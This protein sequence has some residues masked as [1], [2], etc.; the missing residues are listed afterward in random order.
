MG[1]LLCSD[2]GYE[3]LDGEYCCSHCGASANKSRRQKTLSN[4]GWI[5][6]CLVFAGPI[7][8]S[9]FLAVTGFQLGLW[10]ILGIFIQGYFFL[11]G[12][13]NKNTIQGFLACLILSAIAV[14]I[15]LAESDIDSFYYLVF[16]SFVFSIFFHFIFKKDI[17]YRINEPVLLIWNII[18]LYIYCLKF[19]INNVPAIIFIF[20]SFINFAEIIS[21]SPPKF[22]SR[23]I[24]YCWFLFML[25][26]VSAYQFD[27]KIFLAF[28]GGENFPAASGPLDAVLSGM[29]FLYI[30]SYSLF[31]LVFLFL[32]IPVTSGPL[33]KFNFKKRKEGIK[34]QAILLSDAFDVRSFSIKFILFLVFLSGGG[35]AINHYFNLIPDYFLIDALL[36]FSFYFLNFHSPKNTLPLEF[37]VKD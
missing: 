25:I 34:K 9:F 14:S 24:I 22:L 11:G 15:F 7:I 12:N 31:I 27:F 10:F 17:L 30:V 28:A 3:I 16:F 19:G 20:L 32:I 35:L 2:C 8:I 13:L 5:L 33:E 4:I 18:F 26:F 29:I 37:V 21:R 36:I 23:V 6:L 1:K